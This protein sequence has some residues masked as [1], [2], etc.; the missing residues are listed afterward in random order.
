MEFKNN[1]SDFNKCSSGFCCTEIENLCVTKGNQEILK[2]V[3]LHVHCGELT[4]YDPI[5][6]SAYERNNSGF[7]GRG[8]GLNKYTGA[9]GKSGA[10]DANAEFVAQI[11]GIFEKNN[12]K[13][14]VAELGKIDIGGGGTIAYILANKG[15]DVI[16]CGVP[17]LSMHAPYEVTSK[18]DIYETYRAYE[19]FWKN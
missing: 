6:A 18:F 13:Y 12:I 10:S 1:K 17:V 16:D 4:A 8:V 11:R 14:E 2:D 9:R 3:N 5:Y 19:A 15:V 7:L